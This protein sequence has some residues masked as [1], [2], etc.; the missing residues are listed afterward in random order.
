MQLIVFTKMM[1]HL[2][3]A[4]LAAFGKRVGLDGFDLCV[5]AGHPVNPANAA[6][7]LPAAVRVFREAG[8]SIPMIT[9]EADLTDPTNP[10]AEKLFAAMAQAEVKLFK[11]PYYRFKYLAQDYWTEFAR[12]VEQITAWLAL[13]EKYDI[14][15]CY[16][17]HSHDIENG[18]ANYV[19]SNCS[20]LA[21]LIHAVDS[22]KLGAYIDPGHMLVN[23][24]HISLGVALVQK[25]LRIVA[26]KDIMLAREE[27]HGHGYSRR[28]FVKA[29]QGMVDWTEVFAELQRV[30]FSGPITVHCE[31]DDIPD[32]E[33]MATVEEE[34]TFFRQQIDALA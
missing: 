2:D 5:R 25:Q 13:A 15:V 3:V 1:S 33:F 22:P 34:V 8:L 24:E 27:R 12:A 6:E 23:G 17:T 9:G 10:E 21:H 7:A 20:G 4:A 26:V 28:K 19:G 14:E 29:G 30:D 11:L 16:H 32:A 31:I 18:V